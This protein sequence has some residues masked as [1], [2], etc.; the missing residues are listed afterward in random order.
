L[1]NYH[2]L[3]KLIILKTQLDPPIVFFVINFGWWAYLVFFFK[4]INLKIFI[5]CF[6]FSF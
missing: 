5:K 2:R 6:L 1:L 4:K 3:P